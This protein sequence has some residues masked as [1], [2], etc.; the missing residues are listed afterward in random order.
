[1]RK[2]ERES[3]GMQAEDREKERKTREATMLGAVS[4]MGT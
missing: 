2:V 3:E 4:K 1:M